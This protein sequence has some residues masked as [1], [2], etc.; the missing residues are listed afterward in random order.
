[1]P[2]AQSPAALTAQTLAITLGKKKHI[3]L[4]A[5]CRRSGVTMLTKTPSAGQ[6]SAD[7]KPAA[8]KR[9]R[10]RTAAAKVLKRIRQEEAANRKAAVR[11]NAWRRRFWKEELDR[12][13]SPRA[14]WK[15]VGHEL[16][17]IWRGQQG[18]D[19]YWCSVY[20]STPLSQRKNY[21]TAVVRRAMCAYPERSSL[22]KHLRRGLTL[23]ESNL[24]AEALAVSLMEQHFL[25]K[26]PRRTEKRGR[27]KRRWAR[28]CA[29]IAIK[30]YRDWKEANRRNGICDWGHGDEMKDEAC[31]LAIELNGDVP[32]HMPPE[33]PPTPEDLRELVDRAQARRS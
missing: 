6:A 23:V 25:I 32:S 5:V 1:L 14:N 27:P 18:C 10:A 15:D 11:Y 21:W 29:R 30:F 22:V 17:K 26:R 2:F 3:V 24:L 33:D 8:R 4:A 16:Q 12:A 13:I 9:A 31:R 7:V 20:P 28:S 19:C